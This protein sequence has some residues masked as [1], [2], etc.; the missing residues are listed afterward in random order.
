MPPGEPLHYPVEPP[1][2][3][4]ERIVLGALERPSSSRDCA[5]DLRL[6]GM[7]SDIVSNALTRAL[8]KPEDDVRSFLDGVNGR[9]A[10][11]D[12]LLEASAEEFGVE[13]AVL[14]KEV[15]RFRH[16]NC[17]HAGGGDPADRKR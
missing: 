6:P 15:K 12:E 16:C 8:G 2:E 5:V 14:R 11:G 7:M 4:I 1:D 17:T 10:T 13:A 3:R 9:Y